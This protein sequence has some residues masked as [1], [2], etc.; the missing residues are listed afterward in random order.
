M[1]TAT[2]YKTLGEGIKNSILAPNEARLKLGL[3]PVQGGDSPMAQQ[4]EFS[5][6]ALSKRD[7]GD[8]FAKPEPAPQP[9]PEPDDTS[10]EQARALIE[11]HPQGACPMLDVETLGR[12][13]VA[14]VREYVGKRAVDSLQAARP[15]ARDASRC[16]RSAWPSWST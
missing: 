2:Q 11:S 9:E 14:L 10:A 3:P 7:A 13:L 16:P 4:Q 5:L 12:E 6:E 15:G 8:P 1:D